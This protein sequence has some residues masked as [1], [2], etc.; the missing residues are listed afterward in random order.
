M[1]EYMVIIKSEGPNQL[2]QEMAMALTYMMDHKQ[3]LE[4]M[5][6]EEPIQLTPLTF[7]Q[8]QE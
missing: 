1:R 6:I 4:D 3:E 5:Y 8:R 2:M 7:I